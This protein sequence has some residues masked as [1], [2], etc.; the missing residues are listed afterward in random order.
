MQELEPRFLQVGD[1]LFPIEHSNTQSPMFEIHEI[2]LKGK[3]KSAIHIKENGN[4]LYFRRTLW[5]N[6]GV[7]KTTLRGDSPEKFALHEK[8]V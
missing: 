1:I 8:T 6:N 3:G 2:A 5:K 7:W 4:K